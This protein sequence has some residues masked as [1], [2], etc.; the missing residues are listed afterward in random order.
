[1]NL[2]V[3]IPFHPEIKFRANSGNQFKPIRN[4]L[5]IFINPL[6]RISAFRW[7]IHSPDW[8]TMLNPISAVKFLEPRKV[9][10]DSLPGLCLKCKGPHSLG[11]LIE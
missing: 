4:R 10:L 6:Q 3:Q 2:L 5:N 11:T 9:P 1:M 7:G 8:L